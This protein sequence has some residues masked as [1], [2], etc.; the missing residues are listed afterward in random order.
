MGVR[1]G[2]GVGELFRLG[3]WFMWAGTGEWFRSGRG[4][5]IQLKR[6]GGGWFISE[7]ARNSAS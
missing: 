5:V 2:S 4:E 1:V 7:G 3:D 6:G